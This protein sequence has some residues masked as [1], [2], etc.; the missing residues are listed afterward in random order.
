MSRPLKDASRKNRLVAPASRLHRSGRSVL[1]EGHAAQVFDAA[2]ASRIVRLRS[3]ASLAVREPDAGAVIQRRFSNVAS[4]SVRCS[5]WPHVRGALLAQVD[6]AP[7]SADCGAWSYHAPQ[8]RISEDGLAELA[9]VVL[10]DLRR[11]EVVQEGNVFSVKHVDGG[12][13]RRL[14]VIDRAT[15]KSTPSSRLHPWPRSQRR[16]WWRRRR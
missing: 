15:G 14:G 13:Q 11:V 10:G 3:R 7:I 4:L 5:V 6:I 9:H 12:L 8:Q 2:Q 1:L 16:S